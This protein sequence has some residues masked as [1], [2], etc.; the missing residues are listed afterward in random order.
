MVRIGRVKIHDIIDTFAWNSFENLFY[1]FAVW[2]DN[3]DTL[4]LVDVLNDHVFEQHGL[5]GTGFTEHIHVLA[6]VFS[7]DAE[8]LISTSE[9]RL[10]EVR[11][12][13]VEWKIH[14]LVF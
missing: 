13:F 2:V 14:R 5:T 9:V 7:F 12:V 8:N 6:A 1:Q 11:Y 3:A 10:R 4:P